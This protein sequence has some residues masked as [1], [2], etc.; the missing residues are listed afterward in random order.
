[1]GWRLS[2]IFRLCFASIVVLFLS[3][4]NISCSS[5]APL[6]LDLTL[7]KDLPRFDDNGYRLNP[8]WLSQVLQGQGFTP[9]DPLKCAPSGG[10]QDHPEKWA[11]CTHLAVTTNR[12]A[13]C[14]PHVNW[15][16]VAYS[17]NAI[18]FDNHSTWNYD[19]FSKDDDYNVELVRNDHALYSANKPVDQN[20][21]LHS[22][23]DAAETMSHF[24]TPWWVAFRNKVD[25]DDSVND[26]NFT[27]AKAFLATSKGALAIGMLGL[28]CADRHS[29]DAELHPVWVLAIHV[30]DNYCPAPPHGGPTSCYDHWAFFARNKGDEGYCSGA[31]ENLYPVNNTGAANY[32]YRMLLPGVTAAPSTAYVELYHNGNSYSANGYF[33]YQKVQDGLQL[34]FTLPNPDNENEDD[35]WSIDGDIY[36]LRPS[37]RPSPLPTL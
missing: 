31:K 9:A 28:D 13:L 12:G 3:G 6:P 37:L 30:D 27:T 32:Q 8:T 29:C 5:T 1:M 35:D 23:F 4:C 11:A 16:P 24:A 25:F 33:S 34:I 7:A 15:G 10:D 19:N 20:A 14:G 18:V 21:Q 26:H 22:E 36:F 17:A 2:R